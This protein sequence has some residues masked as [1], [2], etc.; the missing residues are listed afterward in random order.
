MGDEEEVVTTYI[1]EIKVDEDN[2]GYE[3]DDN[4]IEEY[5]DEVSECEDDKEEFKK[6]VVATFTNNFSTPMDRLNPLRDKIRVERTPR[7][8]ESMR[9]YKKN[10]NG[11]YE[12]PKCPTTF[13]F[14][15]RLELH[16]DIEHGY[17]GQASFQCSHCGD[18]F[19]LFKELKYH[20]DNVHT[21]KFLSLSLK[22]SSNF[23]YF[24]SSTIYLRPL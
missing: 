16:L 23:I 10:Q 11:Q 20:V 17:E 19:T 21:R 6:P 14:L 24:F 18:I 8:K 22:L 3:D 4:I 9:L 2:E 5:L 13:S 1:E 7:R 12:C 15:G